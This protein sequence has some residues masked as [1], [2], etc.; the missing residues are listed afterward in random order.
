MFLIFL[1]CKKGGEKGFCC[2]FLKGGK[3]FC[4]LELFI[5]LDVVYIYIYA[6]LYVWFF[7]ILY[8]Y[9]KSFCINIQKVLA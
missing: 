1:L 8:V 2:F 3:Y 6:T 7:I 9:A 5:L 4:I